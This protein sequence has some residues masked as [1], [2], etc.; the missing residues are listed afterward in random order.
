MCAMTWFLTPAVRLMNRLRYPQ[1]FALIS[2]VFAIPIG[3]M[4]GLWLVELHGRIA[5]TASERKGLEYIVALRNVLEPLDHARALRPMAEAGD[6]AAR[7]RLAE[8]QVQIVAAATVVDSL[9]ARLGRELG[10]QDLWRSVRPRVAH[11]AVAPGTLTSQLRQ[12]I[13]QISDASK[14]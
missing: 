11:P 2:L 6:P 5:F 4:M 1:K 8:V 12:L 7:E 3:L 10:V 14:L 9:N 13:E